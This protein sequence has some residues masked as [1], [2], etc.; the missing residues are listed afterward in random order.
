MHETRKIGF[1]Y[2]WKRSTNMLKK[3]PRIMKLN[4]GRFY[5]RE[6]SSIWDLDAFGQRYLV[7]DELIF[8]QSHLRRMMPLYSRSIKW[9]TCNPSWRIMRFQYNNGHLK[10]E[11]PDLESTF[12]ENL[13]SLWRTARFE[14]KCLEFYAAHCENVFT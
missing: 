2:C 3:H 1:K 6:A 11:V 7:R 10:S 8:A 12:K 5:A 14:M 13:P 4:Y 9:R